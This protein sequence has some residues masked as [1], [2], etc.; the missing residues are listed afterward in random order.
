MA[1]ATPSSQV[2]ITGADTSDWLTPSSFLEF[3]SDEPAAISIDADGV[4]TLH[5]N[6]FSPVTL[7]ASEGCGGS[8]AGSLAV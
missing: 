5:A 4:A 3:A 1:L 7:T 2:G 8:A 6:F